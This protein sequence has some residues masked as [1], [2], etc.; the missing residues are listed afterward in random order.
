MTAVR[1][2]TPAEAAGLT[3]ALM[4]LAIRAKG[5]W[6]YDDAFLASFRDSMLGPF[7]APGSTVLV[8]EPESGELLGFAMVQDRGDHCWLEDLWVDPSW[9][10]R[11]LGA[12]L[13]EAAVAHARSV[14]HDRLDLESDPN[15][16]P[17]YAA[18]GCTR[19]AVR[20][21]AL[22]PGTTLPLM[23]LRLR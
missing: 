20:S 9:Q 3:P 21:S 23:R 13:F 6:G 1:A 15:A 5:V 4:D 17:F 11:G 7:D 10:R 12:Q 19:Y 8:A 22:R 16:E 18:M 2:L 14:G